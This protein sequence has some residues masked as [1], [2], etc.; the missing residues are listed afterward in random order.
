MRDSRTGASSHHHG[1][2]KNGGADFDGNND[3][4]GIAISKN[5]Y[6]REW[7]V[8]PGYSSG[9]SSN[10]GDDNDND[11]DSM[12]SSHHSSRSLPGT[13]G[14]SAKEYVSVIHRTGSHPDLLA[15]DT[16][17]QTIVDQGGLT[18]A[19]VRIATPFGK[20]IEEIYDG[21]HDGPVLGSG[22][23]G[24]VRLILHRATGLK[25]AVKILDLGMIDSAQGLKQLRDEIFIMCQL[26]HPN[27]VRCVS[28]EL[29]LPACGVS[30][31]ALFTSPNS[32]DSLLYFSPSSLSPSLQGSRKCTSP[33]MKFTS[34]RSCA[35]EEICLTGS[36]SRQTTT[37]P[38]PRVLASSSKC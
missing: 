19:L 33:P 17:R 12:S 18:E 28:V 10:G 25:Y 1:N 16:L 9:A 20:P 2:D 21:V 35:S 5:R 34:S 32:Y 30:S 22:V 26:D 4:S 23:S 31:S 27:I 37:T 14:K 11:N 38:R 3:K 13:V 36:T 8:R 15:L 29:V 7:G 24:L 6:T